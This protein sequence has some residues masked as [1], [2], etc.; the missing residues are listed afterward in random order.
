[1]DI[2]PEEPQNQLKV[3]KTGYGAGK[4]RGLNIGR[5]SQAKVGLI[6]EE[7]KLK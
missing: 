6:I 5:D 4:E 3:R 1:M 2:L 7:Q